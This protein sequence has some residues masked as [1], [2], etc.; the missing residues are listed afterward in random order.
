MGKLLPF[1][2]P[3]NE[4]NSEKYLSGLMCIE[5]GCDEKAGTAWSPYW[6]F[7]CNVKRIKRISRQLDDF[8]RVK[9]GGKDG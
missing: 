2:D 9:N 1:E 8:I 6:C 5:S 7:N 4:G 3:A